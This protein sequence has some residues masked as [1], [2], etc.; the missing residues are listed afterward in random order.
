MR[1]TCSSCKNS[2]ET[3]A[4]SGAVEC[5][6]CHN[7]VAIPAQKKGIPIISS[8]PKPVKYVLTVVLAVVLVVM[9]LNLLGILK[10]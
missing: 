2:F 3:I 10:L 9:I 7:L 1:L 4:V 8:L 5:P 6:A